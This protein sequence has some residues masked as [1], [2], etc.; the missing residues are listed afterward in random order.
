[1]RKTIL[2]IMQS[3]PNI[4]DS[5]CY[6]RSCCRL[7]EL[8]A[9]SKEGEKKKALAASKVDMVKAVLPKEKQAELDRQKKAAEKDWADLVKQMDN[10][11][12]V[13]VLS[14]VVVLKIAQDWIKFHLERRRETFS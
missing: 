11:Q 14:H 13:I 12:Y 10:T 6:I 8:M 3:K 7:Q 2:V 5:E 4:T 9:N 1:M